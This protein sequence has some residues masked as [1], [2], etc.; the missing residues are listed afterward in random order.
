V[1]HFLLTLL[2]GLWGLGAGVLA[3]HLASTGPTHPVHWTAVDVLEPQT[4][5]VGGS[6]P[7]IGGDSQ[8]V[9]ARTTD[10][11]RRWTVTPVAAD[12]LVVRLD[13]MSP[14]VGWAALVPTRCIPVT[15]CGLDLERTDDGGRRWLAAGSVQ[16][17]LP[18][19]EN[20]RYVS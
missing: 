17:R 15:G 1:K 14:Q 18:D 12:A 13:M 11:G 19:A 20:R 9:V 6:R 2:V 3:P 10:G 5:W 7:G 16:F 4:V 8:A